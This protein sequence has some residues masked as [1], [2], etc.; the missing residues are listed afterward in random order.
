MATVFSR[1]S[2]HDQVPRPL[3][4]GG[5]RRL[6]VMAEPEDTDPRPLRLRR[7]GIDTYQEAVVYMH[8]DC[9]VCRAEGFAAQSRVQVEVGDRSLVA[10]RETAVIEVTVHPSEFHPAEATLLAQQTPP[11]PNWNP[12]ASALEQRWEEI[13]GCQELFGTPRQPIDTG[14]D[15]FEFQSIDIDG[16]D[17]VV[18]VEVDLWSDYDGG[19]E[20]P[21]HARDVT[22]FTFWM[23][24]DGG[25]WK[26]TRQ[27]ADI[28]HD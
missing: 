3:S 14:V 19:G 11:T 18:L 5:I 9:H 2:S 10:Y 15:S 26:I 24:K 22:P 17:A 21:Y 13:D 23:H 27:A 20:Q 1:K 4:A 25:V 6:A 12:Y 16:S 7:L 28:F 8:R